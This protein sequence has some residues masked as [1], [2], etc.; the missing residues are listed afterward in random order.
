MPQDIKKTMQNRARELQNEA[1][2]PCRLP[3]ATPGRPGVA[4]GAPEKEGSP[5]KSHFWAEKCDF[6]VL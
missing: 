3:G 2:N 4:P 6:E 1:L 5:P